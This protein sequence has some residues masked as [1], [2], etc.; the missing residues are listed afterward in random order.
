MNDHQRHEDKEEE[1]FKAG[2]NLQNILDLLQQLAFLFDYLKNSEQPC[3][4]DQFMNSTDSGQSNHL[5][6]RA[7]C[8]TTLIN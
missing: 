8:F 1:S 4:L 5:I 3:Q 2:T 6:I 7:A